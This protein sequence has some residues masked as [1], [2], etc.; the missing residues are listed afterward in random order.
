MNA[1]RK[2]QVIET[3]STNNARNQK[4]F[5]PKSEFIVYNEKRARFE[6]DVECN[7]I[8]DAVGIYNFCSTTIDDTKYYLDFEAVILDE[9]NTDSI[10]IRIYGF[11]TTPS[12]DIEEYDID[13]DDDIELW[14]MGNNEIE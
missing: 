9:Y 13:E 1:D 7:G 8:D 11:Q 14:E 6:F 4:E 12:Y 5:T 3:L 2:Q 10:E